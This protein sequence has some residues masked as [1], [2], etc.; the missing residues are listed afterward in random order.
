MLMTWTKLT[1]ET[2]RLSALQIGIMLIL[3][4]HALCAQVWLLAVRHISVIVAQFSLQGRSYLWF[5]GEW[6]KLLTLTR[7]QR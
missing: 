2:P 6:A 1:L 4:T 3:S 7:K 5:S